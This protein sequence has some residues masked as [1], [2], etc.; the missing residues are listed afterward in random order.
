MVTCVVALKEEVT[1][2]SIYDKAE[3]SDIQDKELERL[4]KENELN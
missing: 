1:L 3:Q 4:L 2:L